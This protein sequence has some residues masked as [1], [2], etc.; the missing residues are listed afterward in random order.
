M[1]I[2]DLDTLH[3]RMDHMGAVYRKAGTPRVAHLDITYRCDLDCV[4]CYL[5]EKNKWPEMNT[6]QWRDTLDQLAQIGV[7]ELVWSGGE[8]FARPDFPALLE[9]ASSKGFRSRVKTHAGN[10]GAERAQF[11]RD[12]GVWRADISVYSL[13]DGIHDGITGIEGSLQATIRGVDALI[14]AD[15]VVQ[16]SVIVMRAN[17][18]ELSELDI[19][20][21][22]KGA[23]PAFSTQIF[24]DQSASSN[25][26]TLQ[27]TGEELLDAN[28][29]IAAIRLRTFGDAAKIL[30][31]FDS[32]SGVCG[33][34]ATLVYITPDGSV[35][36]CI[37]F[38]MSLGHLRE[39]TLAEIW[40]GSK[41]RK[42]LAGF[43]KKDR[44]ACT[45]C[46]GKE[47]CFYC[48]GEAYKRTGNY[49]Q[50]PDAFHMRAH[51]HMVVGKEM[52]GQEFSDKDFASVP[53]FDAGHLTAP[54]RKF[55]FPIYRPDRLD[56]AP[57]A[58]K[59]E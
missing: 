5:D 55:V 10:V 25:L 3:R 17:M 22:D 53:D 39:N 12:N 48:P 19:F 28:R 4:H 30:T 56:A 26:D 45:S 49:R 59:S 31:P 50:A 9:Y 20:F 57:A 36:P 54:K 58:E 47:V 13:D 52:L 32:E 11:L 40:H 18:Y 51:A 6:S 44:T 15:I 2:Q 34:G 41:E 16:A 21:R 27:L 35:C 42:E 46:G 43:K 14:A 1:I 23:R 37:Q 29:S 38:P 24:P 7:W 8:V 33:A